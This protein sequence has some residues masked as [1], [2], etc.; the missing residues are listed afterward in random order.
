MNGGV[1]RTEEALVHARFE[2][3]DART[4]RLSFARRAI[5]DAAPV[6]RPSRHLIVSWIRRQARGDAARGFDEPHVLRLRL[7]IEAIGGDRLLVGRQRRAMYPVA[8]GRWR[9]WCR[10]D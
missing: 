3:S 7:R 9:A 6:R 4:A 1:R 10:T 8:P 2:R 5:E